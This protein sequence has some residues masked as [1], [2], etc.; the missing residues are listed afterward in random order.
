MND[1][2]YCQLL[3]RNFKMWLEEFKEIFDKRVLWDCL[4][5][6]SQLCGC[7]DLDTCFSQFEKSLPQPEIKVR[8]EILFNLRSTVVCLIQSFTE[9]PVFE[10]PFAHPMILILSYL[11]ENSI[12]RVSV[13]CKLA[14][15]WYEERPTYL[16]VTANCTNYIF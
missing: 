11:V 12:Y 4:K 10:C 7:A 3:D 2:E 13:I 9:K 16:T 1:N 15:E 6:H 14:M 8:L 5:G